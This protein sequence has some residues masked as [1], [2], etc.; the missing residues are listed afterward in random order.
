MT[1]ANR[2]RHLTLIDVL[3]L[4]I[5]I[6]VII[7]CLRGVFGDAK[8]QSQKSTCIGN[9]KLLGQALQAYAQ[10]FDNTLPVCSYREPAKHA[11]GWG[12]HWPD[13]PKSA[14]MSWADAL[15]P[16]VKDRSVF[17][18]PQRPDLPLNIGFGNPTATL[19]YSMNALF[20]TLKSNRLSDVTNPSAKILLCES[21]LGIGQMEPFLLNDIDKAGKKHIMPNFLFADWH[22]AALSVKDTIYPIVMWNPNDK[23]PLAIPVGKV[24]CLNDKDLQVYLATLLK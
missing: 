21:T 14:C 6:A 1:Y 15:L 7:G 2:R 16:Y 23:Y 22:V 24:T 19:S 3:L 4:T 18:C 9:L 8:A 10:D 11:N 20:N 5:S 12:L 17:A 13:D